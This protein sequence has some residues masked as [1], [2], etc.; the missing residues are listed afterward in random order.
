[1]ANLKWRFGP[2]VC[3]LGVELSDGEAEFLAS[4]IGLILHSI[5]PESARYRNLES[6][7]RRLRKSSVLQMS[8]GERAHLA[9]ELNDMRLEAGSVES[10]LRTAVSRKLGRPE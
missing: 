7:L 1:M 5:L 2:K 8:E 3:D 4:R 9:R 6:I 10:A